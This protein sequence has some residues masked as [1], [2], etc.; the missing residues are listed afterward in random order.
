MRIPAMAVLLGSLLVSAA[1]A[2][3]VSPDS[4]SVGAVGQV[5]R[6]VRGEIVSARAVAIEG[7]TGIGTTAGAG[8]GAVAGSTIGNSVE[9]SIVGAI[10]GAVIGGLAGAMVEESAT[11]QTGME[12]IVETSNG[13]L[14]TVVQGVE[15]ILAVGQPVMVIYGQRSRVI[16]DDG[17]R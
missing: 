2:P 9:A 7:T 6:V 3:E 15:P 1:C 12:Y 17:G 11:A 8:A 5:N 10:G 13:A 16:A 4:Y 14:L